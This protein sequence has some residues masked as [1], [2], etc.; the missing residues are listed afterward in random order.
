MHPTTAI[1]GREPAA[2][3]GNCTL[4]ACP[5][6]TSDCSSHLDRLSSVLEPPPPGA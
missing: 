1:V 2:V 4:L 6:G 5:V 3:H